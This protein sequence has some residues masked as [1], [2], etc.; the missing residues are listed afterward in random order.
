MRP[1][2]AHVRL[3]LA[4]RAAA[5]WPLVE[6]AGATACA[7]ACPAGRHLTVAGAPALAYVFNPVPTSPGNAP[8]LAGGTLSTAALSVPAHEPLT[9]SLWYRFEAGVDADPCPLFDF[10]AAASPDLCRVRI[11]GGDVLW[12]YGTAADGRQAAAARVDDGWHH[13]VCANAGAAGAAAVKAIYLDGEPAAVTVGTADGPTGTLTGV[14]LGLGGGGCA[15][16]HV[17][18]FRRVLDGNDARRHYRSGK[19]FVESD[20]VHDRAATRRYA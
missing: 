10:G 5:V 6:A 20:P 11:V 3:L 19:A 1:F 2:G 7:D 13:L 17:A 8:R 18:V 16:S 14:T 12:D 4:D 9:V 15:V